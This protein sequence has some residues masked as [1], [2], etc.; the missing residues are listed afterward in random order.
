MLNKE[1][2]IKVL[3]QNNWGIFLKSS[4]LEEMST[5]NVGKMYK[6]NEVDVDHLVEEYNS[7]LDQPEE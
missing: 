1:L 5:T 6:I 2:L 7:I 3:S 4:P